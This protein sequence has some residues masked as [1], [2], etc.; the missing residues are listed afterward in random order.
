MKAEENV[1]IK[2]KIK[3]ADYCPLSLLSIHNLKENGNEN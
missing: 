1:K 2:I 3:K